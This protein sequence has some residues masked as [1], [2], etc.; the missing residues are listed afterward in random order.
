[1]NKEEI[2]ASLKNLEFDE[3]LSYQM[4]SRMF[5]ILGYLSN[6]TESYL[7]PEEQDYLQRVKGLSKDLL[8]EIHIIL[9]YYRTEHE[10]FKN[11]KHQ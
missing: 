10:K 5:E 9:D 4:H 2:L 1:M 11:N 3:A 8:N 7:P 6:I